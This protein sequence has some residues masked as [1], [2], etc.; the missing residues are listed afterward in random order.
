MKTYPWLV[1]QR[2]EEEEIV[3]EEVLCEEQGVWGFQAVRGWALPPAGGGF[4][5][6]LEPVFGGYFSW[7]G[8][9]VPVRSPASTARKSGRVSNSGERVVDRA[10]RRAAARDLP[11]SGSGSLPSPSP[12]WLR[13]LLG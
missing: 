11:P 12:L 3:G 2:Q 1:R 8:P 6:S 9:P 13:L 7:P 4:G 10:A 5:G